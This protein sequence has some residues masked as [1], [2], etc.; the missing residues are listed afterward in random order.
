MAVAGKDGFCTECS[1]QRAKEK[2]SQP[3]LCRN[4]ACDRPGERRFGGLCVYCHNPPIPPNSPQDLDPSISNQQFPE[5]SRPVDNRSFVSEMYRPMDNEIMFTNQSYTSVAKVPSS[6]APPQ[7]PLRDY[8]GPSNSFVNAAYQ[9]GKYSLTSNE[10][11]LQCCMDNCRNAAE[12]SGLCG[13][14]YQ[15][16][17]QQELTRAENERKNRE[18][19]SLVSRVSQ[20]FVNIIALLQRL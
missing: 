7:L 17:L 15:S 3:P 12:T 8:P 10:E 4:V 1:I 11:V 18:G 13:Q 20:S 5:V 2:A 16:S 9:P 14:C 6:N 19:P